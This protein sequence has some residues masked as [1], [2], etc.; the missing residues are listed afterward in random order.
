MIPGPDFT[1]WLLAVDVEEECS[2][3]TV[4]L[5]CSG[6]LKGTLERI[7]RLF[8]Y[9]YCNLRIAVF[10]KKIPFCHVNLTIFPGVFWVFVCWLVF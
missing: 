1:T 10:G 6:L 5:V 3:S 4:I 9:Q 2:V 7:M 8:L